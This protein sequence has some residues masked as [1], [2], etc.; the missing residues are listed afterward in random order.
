[1]R[2]IF[3]WLI[4]GYQFCVSPFLTPCCRFFPSCSDYAY[5]AFKVHGI[6]NGFFLTIRRLLKC[7][8][9]HSGGIDEVPKESTIPSQWEGYIQTEGDSSPSV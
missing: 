1:M 4:R 3:L 2:N 6:L 7:H 9:W 5:T 8:P